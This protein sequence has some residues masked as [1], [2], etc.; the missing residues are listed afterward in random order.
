M[1][2]TPFHCRV[3]SIILYNLKYTAI[4][5]GAPPPS[6]QGSSR[7]LLWARLSTTCGF[8][9]W[10]KSNSPLVSQ[11]DANYS[12]LLI[13]QLPIQA[14]LSLMR[15]LDVQATLWSKFLRAHLI[16]QCPSSATPSYNVHIL[17]WYEVVSW[18]GQQQGMLL[19]TI[20]RSAVSTIK[21][22]SPSTKVSY[23]P[24]TNNVT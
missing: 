6:R 8:T 12:G 17:N 20:Y 21:A 2:P 14:C 24:Y 13:M 1:P 3:R 11:N 9:Y 23:T 18:W 19:R 5:D 22:W 4:E 16:E 10:Q 7:Q 15:G